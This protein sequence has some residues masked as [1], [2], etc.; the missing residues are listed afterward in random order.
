[1][2]ISFYLLRQSFARVIAFTEGHILLIAPYHP[3]ECHNMTYGQSR[4]GDLAHYYLHKCKVHAKFHEANR[5]FSRAMED[6]ILNIWIAI[7]SILFASNL[8]AV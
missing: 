1:M 5:N 4:L 2:D 8:F 7:H 3:V 6:M